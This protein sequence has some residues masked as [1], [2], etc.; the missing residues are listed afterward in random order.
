MRAI[1][2]ARRSSRHPAVE[3]A[4]IVRIAF[5]IPGFDPSRGGV[6]RY[7][8]TLASALVERG[9]SVRVLL[10][11]PA[12]PRGE[13]DAGVE[14]EP[15]PVPRG[16]RLT[17][18]RRFDRAVRERLAASRERFDL[19]QGFGRTTCH[20][21]YRVGGGTHRAYLRALRPYR[22]AAAR[23]RD[24]LRPKTRLVLRAERAIFSQPGVRYIAN[25]ERTRD[26][27]VRDHGVE[28]GRI[29]VIHNGVDTRAF[30]P[31]RC[32]SRRKELRE[33]WGLPETAWVGAFV[34][35]GFERKGL[36]YALRALAALRARGT[37]GRLLVAGRGRSGTYRREAAA[38][39]VA[40]SVRWLGPVRDVEAVYAA[41]DYAILPSLYEPFGIAPLEALACGLPVVVT[42][43]CGV[44]ELL[45]EGRE[46]VLLP[47]PER[48]PEA[49]GFL[50]RL[51]ADPE[52]RGAV[53][54]RARATAE[55]NDLPSH[56]ERVLGFYREILEERAARAEP[57]PLS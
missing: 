42:R 19:V 39:G 22:S 26:D 17:R 28:A 45:E 29:R 38:L 6:E 1:V 2:R 7:A 14:L 3:P 4:A 25:S 51:A 21:V 52:L 8:S 5:V 18:A 23:L 43:G 54:A 9:H 24:A 53:A 57:G 12:P 56:V 31:A 13:D 36:R 47:R 41:S 30:Q 15:V 50:E 44:A 46:G 20:D 34:G 11:A 16:P 10:E 27:V 55:A 32:R 37:D 48:A 33:A 35:S 40:E 49:A